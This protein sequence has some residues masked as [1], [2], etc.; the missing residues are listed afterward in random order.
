MSSCMCTYLCV[1]VERAVRREL[2]EH[3]E[4]D[5]GAGGQEQL[6]RQGR[7][8]GGGG[9]ESLLEKVAV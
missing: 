4:P 3:L 9:A 1:H 5:P 8:E 7:V 2:E 6:G